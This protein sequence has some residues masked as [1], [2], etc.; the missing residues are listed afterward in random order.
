M[1][2]I[3]YKHLTSPKHKR[4]IISLSERSDSQECRTTTHKRFIYVVK[5]MPQGENSPNTRP[6]F[7]IH[8]VQNVKTKTEKFSFRVKGLMSITREGQNF[9]VRYSHS[10]NVNIAWKNKLSCAPTTAS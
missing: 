4:K 9:L 10:L 8:K 1:R 2:E 7:Y 3:A 6:Q 5:E